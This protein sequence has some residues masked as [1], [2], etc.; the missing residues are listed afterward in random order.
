MAA[1]LFTE[2][3]ADPL[4]IFPVGSGRPVTTL[5]PAP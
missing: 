3:M 5:E 4:G 1:T 2:A